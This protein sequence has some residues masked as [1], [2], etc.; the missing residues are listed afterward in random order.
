MNRVQ[1]KK[2]T[3]STTFELWYECAPNVKYF[4]EFGSKCYILKDAR[5]GKLDAKSGEGIFLGYSTKIKVYKF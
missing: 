2:G 3:N 1:V 4:K 5:N